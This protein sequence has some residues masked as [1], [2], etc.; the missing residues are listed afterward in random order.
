MSVYV[1]GILYGAA[2]VP[3]TCQLPHTMHSVSHT[4]CNS[5]LT[6]DATSEWRRP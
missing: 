1:F 5:V 2:L 6:V 3:V 4:P